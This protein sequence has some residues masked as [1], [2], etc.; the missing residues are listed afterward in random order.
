MQHH[1]Q[2]V[3]CLALC[4]VVGSAAA[5]QPSAYPAK[6]Q[7]A[8]QKSQDDAACQA[9][10]KTDTGIDPAATAAA[11]AA[12]S[13]P[14]GERIRGAARGAAAGAVIGEVAHGDSSQGAKTGAAAG[15]VAGGARS[16]RNQ[17]AQAQQAASAKTQTIDTYWRAWGA[18]MAGKG[19]TV[20]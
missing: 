13:G 9:W 4:F 2:L 20:Q 14:Q 6:G 3:A 5:Q 15:V 18:C 1:R 17:A 10:A 7:S 11:P 16:R 19:Y 12:T 8:E